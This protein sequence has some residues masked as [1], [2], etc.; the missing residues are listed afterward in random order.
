VGFGFSRLRR[1]ELIV[2]GAAVVLAAALFLM[3][4]YA[5]KGVL[6]PELALTHHATS[7]T[8]WQGLSHLRWLVLITILVAAALV[9]LQ[10]TRRS[11]AWPVT[12]SVLVSVFAFVT[13]L[14]LLYRVVISTP[15]VA[16][17]VDRKYGGFVGLAAS[18][19]MVYGGYL[20][21]RREGLAPGDARTEIETISLRA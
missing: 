7:W 15:D 1:G 10:A 2:G 12:F 16:T 11:P 8:G 14:A 13:T 6:A 5:V 20:S 3:P 17:L 18:A 19:V 4:W 21:M 9:W